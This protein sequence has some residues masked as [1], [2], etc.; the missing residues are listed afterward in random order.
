[1]FAVAH[2]RRLLSAGMDR[3]TIA[4]LLI[5]ALVLFGVVIAS[6]KRYNSRANVIGRRRR[7]EQAAYEKVMADKVE[8]TR[9]SDPM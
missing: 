2:R 1:M 8:I 5:A 4:Y 3:T 9:T 6:L 7:R